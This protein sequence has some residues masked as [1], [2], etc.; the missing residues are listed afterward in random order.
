MCVS[1]TQIYAKELV[2]T[3]HDVV[4][5]LFLKLFFCIFASNMV[6]LYI[7]RG[8]GLTLFCILHFLYGLSARD[9]TDSKRVRFHSI[10]TTFSNS[11][12]VL[13]Q[14]LQKMAQS[15]DHTWNTFSLGAGSSLAFSYA[16]IYDSSWFRFEL[17]A[18]S[19]QGN[20][21]SVLS[22]ADSVDPAILSSY[23]NLKAQK[24]SI[25][26]L[27]GMHQNMGPL[28]Y[29]N[30]SMGVSM[31]FYAPMTRYHSEMDREEEWNY[32]L[33]LMPAYLIQAHWGYWLTSHV[34]LDL[35]A[36]FTLQYLSENKA[37]LTSYREAGKEMEV[38]KQFPN[39]YDRERHYVSSLS[40]ITNDPAINPTSFDPNK[41][42]Q[43]LK[44]TLPFSSISLNFN[45]S[46]WF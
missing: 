45:I 40:D 4:D 1:C 9:V 27:L 30:V 43:A 28:S 39:R 14:S 34:S 18:H 7:Y 15:Q 46:W 19:F 32:R 13:S 21:T 42:S 10:N 6:G 37:K 29:L 3:R 26:L 44:N 35:G 36:A 38:E 31:P 23:S 12:P 8:M 17:G 5:F 41:P 22:M 33:Q 16:R 20:Y 11:W 25:F 2:F 24:Y